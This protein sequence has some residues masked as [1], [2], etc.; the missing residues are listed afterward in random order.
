MKKGI[1]IAVLLFGLPSAIFAQKKGDVEFGFNV[2]YNSSSASDSRDSFDTGMGFN[3]GGAMDYYFSS[4]W[5]IK[6]KLIYDQKGWDNDFIEDT[7][8]NVYPTDINLNYITVPVMANWHFGNKNNWYL[9]FGPYFGFL[10]N[11]EETQFGTDLTDYFNSNDFG[12]ALGIGVKIPVSNK[13]KLFF[14]YDGQGGFSEVL[15]NSSNSDITNTRSSL[16]VGLNFLLK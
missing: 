3:V 8:G 15:K 1:F 4:D 5:S 10:L 7:N 12:L 9:S 13:L 16:N 6:G 2:G 14:E 11:A